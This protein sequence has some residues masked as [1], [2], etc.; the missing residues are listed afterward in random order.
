MIK[1]E[2][3]G[4]FLS[5]VGVS[6]AL[7]AEELHKM[8]PS[9]PLDEALGWCSNMIMAG[10]D[11]GRKLGKKEGIVSLLE[12]AK[13]HYVDGKDEN[14]F[15]MRYVQLYILESFPKSE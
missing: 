5:R 8:Y 7:W 1:T 12:H 3:T 15:V 6:G 4:Q 13:Q 14:G 2:S 9:I 11:A 10:H